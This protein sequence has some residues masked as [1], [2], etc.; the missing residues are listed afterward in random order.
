MN[1]APVIRG[2]T[3]PPSTSIT[4]VPGPGMDGW[5]PSLDASGG[6]HHA[7]ESPRPTVSRIIRSAQIYDKSVLPH[8][9]PDGKG[10][11]LPLNTRRI[12]PNPA[13]NI[14]PPSLAF[15]LICNLLYL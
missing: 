12:L 10:A 2:I 1:L 13:S 9:S 7:N 8:G 4:G 6:L 15:P 5:R 14:S 11:P 3:C